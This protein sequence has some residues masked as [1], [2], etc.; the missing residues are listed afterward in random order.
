[1]KSFVRVAGKLSAAGSETGNVSRHDNTQ[2]SLTFS[3]TVTLSH[4][5]GSIPVFCLVAVI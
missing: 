4:S 1:M 3:V 5:V 2:V